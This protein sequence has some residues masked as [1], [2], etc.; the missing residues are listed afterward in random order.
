MIEWQMVHK[1]RQYIDPRS[2]QYIATASIVEGKLKGGEKVRYQEL[3]ADLAKFENLRPAELPVGAGITDVAPE[4]PS[5]YLLRRGVYDAFKDEVP[6]GL[7]QILDPCPTPIVKP[8]GAQSSG[9][10][11]ALA[12]IFA[13]PANPLTARVMVNRIWHYHFGRGIVGT[14]SDFGFKGDRPT[15]PAL[16]DWLASEF[17]RNGWS[18]KKMHK[19]IMTS[20]TYQQRSRYNELAARTDPDNKLL[21]CFPR[22]RLEGEVIRD[23]GLSVAG[24]LNPKMGGPSVF[25]ELPPGMSPTYSGWKVTDEAEERNRRSVYVFVKRNTRYPLFESFDMPDTHESCSRRSITT[26][27]T[28][29]LNLLNSELTLQWAQGF[30]QRVI[31]L[32]GAD[33]HQQIDAAYRIAFSRHPSSAECEAIKR[34]FERHREIIGE[35]AAA[36]EPLAVPVSLPADADRIEGATLVDLCH[37]LINANEF[38]YR[39]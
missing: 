3:K 18:I 4:P 34:F 1:A 35:R 25:P 21:W 19:L 7:L 29:A 23:A 17:I 37:M 24:L 14:P 9:R 8:K 20:A 30:A 38:V 28:Q 32:A 33:L 11:T 6:A 12:N 10:R 15:H 27:P 31:K 5:T 26:S 16:L 39:N 13:D 22:Q 2:H 36:N